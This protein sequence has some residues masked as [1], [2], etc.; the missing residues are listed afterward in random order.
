MATGGP[1]I[2]PRATPSVD[3]ALAPIVAEATTS[4][5]GA[6]P[7]IPQTRNPMNPQAPPSSGGLGPLQVDVQGTEFAWRPTQQDF[8]QVDVRRGQYDTGQVPTVNVQMPFA[9]LANRQQA[10]A[11][12]KA[13][14]AQKVAAFDRYAGL[15]KA[16]DRFQSAF[17][18]YAVGEMDRKIGEYAQ[19]MFGGDTKAANIFFAT[20]PEGQRLISRWSSELEGIGATNQ[21]FTQSAIDLLADAS[22]GKKYVPP[23]LMKELEQMS[24]AMNP[25]GT[26]VQGVDAG[27]FLQRARNLEGRLHEANYVNEVISPAFKQALKTMAGYDIEKKRV[28]GKYMI[29]ETEKKTFDDAI[30]AYMN[31]D[32]GEE[33]IRLY[34]GGDKAS[35]EKALKGY[36]PTSIKEDIR[37]EA[38][39]SPPS[40]GSGSKLAANSPAAY[41]VTYTPIPQSVFNRKTKKGDTVE[42]FDNPG[43]QMDFPSITLYNMASD[44]ATFPRAY[45]FKTYTGTVNYD[46]DGNRLPSK[47]EQGRVTAHPTDVVNLNGNLWIVARKTTQP[48]ASAVS[49]KQGGD[50]FSSLGAE[51]EGDNIQDFNQLE[52]VMIPY[53]GNEAIVEAGF[54][55][56]EQGLKDALLPHKAK[57][58]EG[59]KSTTKQSADPLG[60]L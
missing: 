33:Y 19:A 54:G 51:G 55:Y 7:P 30:D 23:E 37:L 52:V 29:T 36:F 10:I 44:Q 42:V 43:A 60:I 35:A 17:N 28:G 45:E 34:H 13:A 25:D 1:Y 4:T 53:K 38:P 18:K 5:T 48:R 6:P 9:A 8:G 47:S 14:L 58:R 40:G 57:L 24:M 22:L 31:S 41:N 56:T 16:H 50:P 21:A 49:K 59:A 46:K 27:E 15:G 26:P 3:E 39:Y 20:D 11:N 32:D 12:R 2:D